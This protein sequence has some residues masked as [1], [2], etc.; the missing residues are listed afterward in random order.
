MFLRNIFCI[1]SIKSSFDEY[2]S[3]S[4]VLHIFFLFEFLIVGKSVGR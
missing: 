1:A 3:E 2:P 4:Y